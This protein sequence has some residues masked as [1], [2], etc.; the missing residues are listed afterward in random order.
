MVAET[1]DVYVLVLPPSEPLAAYA[2]PYLEG[3]PGSFYSSS[4]SPRDSELCNWFCVADKS[5][6][7]YCELFLPPNGFG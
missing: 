7:Y 5:G 2:G 1:V 3:N 6:V 4:G